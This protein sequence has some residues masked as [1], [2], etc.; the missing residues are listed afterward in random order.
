MLAGI[1]EIVGVSM[2]DGSWNEQKWE[3]MEVIGAWRSASGDAVFG[4]VVDKRNAE[5][6]QWGFKSPGAWL[7]M[8][9][10][11]KHLRDPV[12]LAI[13]KDPVSVAQRRFSGGPDHF[14]W[15]LRNTG[16]KLR[17]SF[18]GI[19]ACRVPVAV[20]SYLK[21]VVRPRLFVEQVAEAV[22]LT[23]TSDQIDRAS[24]FIQPNL[25]G[26]QASYPSVREHLAR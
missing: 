8:P 10:M 3:D 2:M 25:G 15:K 21:A 23:P 20:F 13:Y 17:N 9:R 22:G 4:A 7:W 24:R 18:E 11:Q 16:Y 12:Y 5:H 14:L 6:E 26:P 1:L 19:Y